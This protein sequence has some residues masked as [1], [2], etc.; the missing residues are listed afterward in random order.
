MRGR[1]P[2]FNYLPVAART[3][4]GRNHSAASSIDRPGNRDKSLAAIAASSPKSA[5]VYQQIPAGMPPTFSAL[6]R[7]EAR[8][9]VW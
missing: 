5:T 6:R 4:V 3:R 9:H 7:H 8:S 2:T 1:D